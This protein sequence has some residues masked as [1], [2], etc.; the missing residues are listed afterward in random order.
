M[1]AVDQ[2]IEF[3]EQRTPFS[4]HFRLFRSWNPP[5]DIRYIVLIMSTISQYHEL[6]SPAQPV[7]QPTG[8]S[9]RAFL[10]SVASHLALVGYSTYRPLLSRNLANETPIAQVSGDA[11]GLW[12]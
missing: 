7:S 2:Y 5:W 3:R 12:R 1:S 9:L 8:Q 4:L 10:A 11:L 6:G